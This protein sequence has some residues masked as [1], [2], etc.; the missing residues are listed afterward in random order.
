M[1]QFPKLNLLLS[2]AYESDQI[3]KALTEKQ[4][5]LRVLIDSGAFTAHTLGKNITLDNY[6]NWL[7]KLP[8]APE[9]YFNLDV[10][11]SPEESFDNYQEMLRRGFKPIPIITHG[12]SI[13]EI[14]EYE[15]E[16]D[17]ISLGGIVQVVNKEKYINQ[18]TNLASSKFH[19]LGYTKPEG[20]KY[21]KPYSCDSST[22]TASKRYGDLAI[23]ENGQMRIYKQKNAEGLFKKANN[24]L[25][26]RG[27][28]IND[29]KK[30]ESWRGKTFPLIEQVSIDSWVRFSLDCGPKLDTLLYLVV[31]TADDVENLYNAYKKVLS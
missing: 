10:I 25:T 1:S 20:L 9:G 30:N 31:A 4:K 29:F 21:F 8:F 19:L 2:Y 22:W 26:R 11:G 16:T 13:E 3:I 24:L 6:C 18:F 17:Y 15:K 28:D 5:E 14:K 23:Y 12:D 27:F 7:E